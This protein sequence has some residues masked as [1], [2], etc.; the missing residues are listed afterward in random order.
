[1]IDFSL[2]RALNHLRALPR[3]TCLWS[4]DCK[5]GNRW[6]I[7][8]IVMSFLGYSQLMMP[9]RTTDERAIQI[10]GMGS[11]HMC[12]HRKAKLAVPSLQKEEAI[13]G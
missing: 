4:S 10:I 8:W 12:N 6:R 2:D 3:E 7:A 1:L 5:A 9:I 13:A 11:P